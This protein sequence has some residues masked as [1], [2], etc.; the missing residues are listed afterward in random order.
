MK[1]KRLKEENV[2]VIKISKEALFEFIYEKFIEEQDIFFDVN[3]LQ[4]M[5]SFD[6]D[7][8]EGKFIFCVHISED[9]NKNSIPLPKEINLKKIMNSIPD[10]TPTMFTE[11]RYCE[12][13]KQELIELS[14]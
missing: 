12:Y 6:I 5:D 3:S 13:S 4:V 2:R 1:N 14:K 8:E 11:N 10:T 9:S 7:W